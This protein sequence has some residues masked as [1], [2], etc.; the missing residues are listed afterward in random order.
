MDRFTNGITSLGLLGSTYVS[1]DLG[2]AAAGRTST[3]IS[4]TG[5][6]DRY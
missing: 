2:D 6:L 4:L 1:V 3:A 5:F